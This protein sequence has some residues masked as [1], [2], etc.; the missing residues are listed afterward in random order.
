MPL[1][2][3]S[4]LMPQYLPLSTVSL[5]PLQFY[6]MN[7]HPQSVGPLPPL[8]FWTGM[9]TI[10]TASANSVKSDLGCT[11][12]VYFV[13]VTL[14]SHNRTLMSQKP[15]Q[16]NNRSNC[17]KANGYNIPQDIAI[18]YWKTLNFIYSVHVIMDIDRAEPNAIA[19]FFLI[20]CAHPCSISN[21]FKLQ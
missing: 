15:C 19:Q 12:R 17:S 6:S 5:F 9:R 8:H 21:N 20:P 16:Y 10:R 7:I 13:N 11:S 18:S 1:S 14:T 3:A 2:R 4:L